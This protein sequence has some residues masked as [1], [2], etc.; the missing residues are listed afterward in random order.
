MQSQP[1]YHNYTTS[2]TCSNKTNK[3]EHIKTSNYNKG[4]ATRKFAF[5][6]KLYTVEMFEHT[7]KK[8]NMLTQIHFCF[9]HRINTNNKTRVNHT[10][11]A[12]KL[13]INDS[14]INAGSRVCS[15]ASLPVQQ[16][17]QQYNNKNNKAYEVNTWLSYKQSSM[18]HAMISMYIVCIWTWFI[19]TITNLNYICWLYSYVGYGC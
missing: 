6:L 9:S 3:L 12:H 16:D 18:F 1:N 11:H 10:H 14:K 15:C 19:T 4:K 17:W 7:K 13:H 2:W 8:R 5:L